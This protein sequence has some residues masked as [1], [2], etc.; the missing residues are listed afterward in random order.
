MKSRRDAILEGSKAAARL[1]DELEMRR[2]VEAQASSVDVFGTIVRQRIPLVFK[3][4]DGL[5]GAYLPRPIPGIIVTTRRQLSVQRFTGAHELGHARMKHQ[6]SLDD[7]S[8]LTRAESPTAEYDPLETAANAFA[9]DF[10]LPQWLLISQAARHKWSRK[11]LTNPSV[12]Y[13]LS[14]RAGASFQAT[15]LALLRHNL[16]VQQTFDALHDT[17]VKRIKQEL[18]DGHSLENW[19]PDVW[20]LTEADE[21]SM[22]EGDAR[23]AFVLR[24]KESSG[25]GYLWNVED[26][27]N[28]GF[29]LFRDDRLLPDADDDIGGAVERVVS[30]RPGENRVGRITLQ[31]TR[32]WQPAVAPIS[33]LSFAFDLRGKESGRPRAERRF[34]TV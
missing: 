24:L 21:G 25:A 31:Q 29:L 34:A 17:E 6:V 10:L 15:L 12:V 11:D 18:L 16:I 8:M 14:L 3:P 23:D 20:I 1:H 4:L 7:E 19:Y 32:P 33:R 22:I 28:A 30:A 27:K 5:L 26:L 2:Q 9:T 13:Q